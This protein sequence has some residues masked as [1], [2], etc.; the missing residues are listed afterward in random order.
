MPEVPTKFPR[1]RL[2]D[3]QG[4]ITRIRAKLNPK[5]AVRL[6]PYCDVIISMRMQGVELRQ[7]EKWLIEQGD[8]FRIPANTIH[9]C[10]QRTNLP[11][12]LTYAE[13]M[14]EKLG[15]Q[16]DVNLV[17]EMSKNVWI[18]KQRVDQMVRDEQTR[19]AQP[20]NETYTDRRVRHELEVYNMLLQALHTVL[21]EAPVKAQQAAKAEQQRLDSQGIAASKD[22][23]VVLR[24][25]ILNNELV[26]GGSDV[27]P[28]SPTKH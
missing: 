12:K 15:G 5:C 2:V 25:L 6:S 9:R 20:N 3:P 28:P 13:E 7:I 8:Q 23:L 11:V 21:Q 26:L 14:L 16:V 19:R 1:V 10:L 17:N 24:D 22:A 27:I 4:M 18:Q